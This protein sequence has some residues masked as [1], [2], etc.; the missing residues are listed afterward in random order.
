[1]QLTYMYQVSD[2]PEEFVPR[3][4]PMDPEKHELIYGSELENGMIVL[5]EDSLVKKDAKNRPA[6]GSTDTPV[7]T[8]Y[9]ESSFQQNNRWCVVTD[10]RRRNDIVQ[11]I[12]L[13]S[14]GTKASR[15]FN[16]SYCWFVMAEAD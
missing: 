13:Y 6:D 14:D 11:F 9:D 2:I 5:I 1:M 12:A 15:R 4:F 8:D 3:V 10:I 16:E 7:W